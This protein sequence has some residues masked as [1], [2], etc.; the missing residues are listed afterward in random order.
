MSNLRVVAELVQQLFAEGE[1]IGVGDGVVEE[2]DALAFVL[3]EPVDGAHHMFRFAE[4]F[5]VEI[6]MHFARPFA[7]KNALY[8]KGFAI[9]HAVVGGGPVN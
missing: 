5:R 1:E 4:V 9:V 3:K 6:G 2:D 7:G 8:L